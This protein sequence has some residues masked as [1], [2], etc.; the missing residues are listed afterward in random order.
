MAWIH[1]SAITN[2]QSKD[3]TIASYQNK[4]KRCSHVLEAAMT[5]KNVMIDVIWDLIANIVN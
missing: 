2:I 1:E 5:S 3:Q 4:A